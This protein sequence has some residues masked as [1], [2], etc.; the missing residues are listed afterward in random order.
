MLNLSAPTG[1]ACSISS[2]PSSAPLSLSQGIGCPAAEMTK[3]K[4]AEL[5]IAAGLENPR[6]IPF[7]ALKSP[8]RF[9][10]HHGPADDRRTIRV[11]PKATE[12]EAQKLIQG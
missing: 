4:L 2:L 12:A 9:H 11:D 8:L 7:K 6:V 3:E 1:R 10:L 5:A